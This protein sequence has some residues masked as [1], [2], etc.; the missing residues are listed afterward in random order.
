MTGGEFLVRVCS[1]V[2]KFL[3]ITKERENEMAD[4]LVLS[5][6]GGMSAVARIE[7]KNDI[8]IDSSKSDSGNFSPKDLFGAAYA[9]CV[10]IT[11]DIAAQK[12]GFD[13]AGAKVNVS[14]KFVM[15]DKPMVGKIDT[16]VVLPK[17][18]SDE[19]MEILRKAANNCPIHNSVSDDVKKTMEFSS[20]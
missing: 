10:A 16:K 13:V 3:E 7:G 9:S 17:E 18:Y 4:E 20:N 14:L 19:Q 1:L 11:M 6:E 5:Y 8:S 2:L 12:N 15:R